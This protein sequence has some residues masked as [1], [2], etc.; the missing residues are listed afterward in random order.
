MVDAIINHV[1]ING[2]AT[3]VPK[4]LDVNKE[5]KYRFAS[6]KQFHRLYNYLKIKTLYKAEQH[7]CTSDLCYAAAESLLSILKWPAN[8][9]DLLVFVSQTPDY[10]LPSTSAM[11]QSRLKLSTT[12]AT[13]DI[14]Q[15]CSGY[16]YGL[17][18]VMSFLQTGYLKRALL[19]AGDTLSKLISDEDLSLDMLFGDA[20]T[21][22]ALEYNPSDS[23]PAFFNLNT[24][25]KTSVLVE[26]RGFR[27]QINSDDQARLQIEGS[28]VVEFTLREVPN[29]IDKL[30]TS[31]CLE[32]N[33]VDYWVLHQANGSMI[34][35]LAE[36][37]CIEGARLPKSYA[38][39]G[40]TSSASIPVTL[41]HSLQQALQD[42]SKT[43][44]LIGYGA[45][46]SFA[47]AL[48]RS[49]NIIIP[50][51]IYV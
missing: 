42:K 16:V 2:I 17:W 51:I 31:A 20:G 19:L 34:Q 41:S 15:G 8:S 7:Q 11:L 24:N 48:I 13:I 36:L 22:T 6:D 50:D 44:G 35:N 29:I 46:L 26:E 27:S 49:Q 21:V 3:A 38:K 10:I 5:K 32:K 47:G 33:C 12:T 37:C 1:N 43:L 18:T 4:K 25:G 23:S 28:S 40:N 9:I 39:F 14:N 45:G 30:L